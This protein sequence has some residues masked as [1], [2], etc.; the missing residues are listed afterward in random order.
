MKLFV[1]DKSFYRQLAVITIPIALQNLINV[2]VS[3]ADTMM[4]G[5]LG[6][7][8]L[9][10][11]SLANQLG[12]VLLLLSFGTG[13]GAGVLIA[14]YWGKREVGPIHM[15]ITLMY[16]VMLAA[17]LLFTA[18][19]VFFPQYVMGVFSTDAGVIAEGASYMRIVGAVF[20]I[21]SLT[22]VTLT[23]LRS[24]RAV[25][26]SVAVSLSAFVT[27]LFLNW[28]FIFGNL[29]APAL[30]VAG[31]AIATAIS[32]LVE[33]CI[34][35]T[36]LLV[37]EKNIRYRA[38]SLF[39]GQVGKIAKSFADTA[40]PVA[41]NELVWSLGAATIAVIIGRMGREFTAAQAIGNVL[42]QFVT[43]ILFAMA[44]ASAVITGNTVGAGEYNKAKEY[45]VTFLVLSG[46]LGLVSGGV[47]LLL[48]DFML[49]M[50]SISE[51]A[52]CY[53]GQ[54]ITI[55]A[56]ITFF[57]SV[58]CT[59][60]VGILRGGGATRF[61]LVVD[62]IFLWLVSIPL[63]FFT[64]LYLGWPVWAVYIILRFDEVLKV[65]ACLPKIFR[66]NWINDITVRH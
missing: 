14:Q 33:F 66:G 65:L 21:W 39:T 63:G 9:S 27:N 13:G 62:A 26:I 16:R 53:G 34:A 54:V 50:Y 61:A 12:F 2:G 10:G 38:K 17:S 6:E 36:Y 28:V 15:A 20:P 3:M 47:V 24:V 60:I 8:Q 4:V 22:T 43:I 42:S 57:Q 23:M 45:G 64:G 58:N 41:L 18:A 55:I 44:N 11:V 51:L 25:N 30:G 56:G 49:S 46:A 48:K 40:M 37:F 32:R 35:C 52:H 59:A 1:R 29:G 5:A 19:A 31:A 7:T